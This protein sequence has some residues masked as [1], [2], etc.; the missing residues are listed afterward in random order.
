MTTGHEY[1]Q[2]R[3][4]EREREMESCTV[5]VWHDTSE[6]QNERGNERKHKDESGSNMDGSV[7]ECMNV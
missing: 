1:I 6:S 3:M 2:T 4:R 5:G 7:Y